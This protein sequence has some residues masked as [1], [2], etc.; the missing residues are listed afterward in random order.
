M[1]DQHQVL[2]LRNVEVTLFL[3]KVEY[4]YTPTHECSRDLMHVSAKEG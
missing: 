3:A 2:V 4:A 1:S